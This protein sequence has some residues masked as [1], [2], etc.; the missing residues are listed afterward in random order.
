MKIDPVV[1]RLEKKSVMQVME[2][3]L[4]RLQKNHM[5]IFILTNHLRIYYAN[6]VATPDFLH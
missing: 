6:A 5:N 1:D 2:R 4:A 3:V